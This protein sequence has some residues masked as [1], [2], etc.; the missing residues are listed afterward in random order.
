MDYRSLPDSEKQRMCL[1]LLA[2]FGARNLRPSGDE[3][4]HSCLLPFGLHR[5]GD[6]NPSASLN[7]RKLAYHCLGCGSGG[8]L[9]W[10]IAVMRGT[11]TSEAKRWIASQTGLGGVQEIGAIIQF[12]DSLQSDSSIQQPSIPK[13]D[14]RVLD[15]WKL[16][17]PYLTGHRMIRE[18]NVIKHRVGFDGSSIIIPHFWQGELVGWQA[19]RLLSSSGPKYKNTPDFPRDRTIYNYIPRKDVVVV[20]SPMSVIARSHQAHVE[21]TFGAAV[22]NKQRGL[23]AAHDQITLFFDNDEAG[24]KATEE[25]GEWLMERTSKVMVVDN[26]W[27][28]DPADMD[29]QTFDSL[30]ANAVPFVLWRRPSSLLLYER[31]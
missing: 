25:V 8:S 16:I 28:A 24:W 11:A 4:I 3:L 30:V 23:I 1:S 17:H 15:K 6:R 2:E 5:N 29:D 7:Y 21:A 18:E 12:L 19:R 27:A 20:E 14:R 31:S 26:P 22:T 9:L 13:Y 10:F